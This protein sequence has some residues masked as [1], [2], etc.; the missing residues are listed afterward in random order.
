MKTVATKLFCAFIFI[1][2]LCKP[3]YNIISMPINKNALIRYK[4]LDRLLSDP[5]HLYSIAEL[6]EAVNNKLV[7]DGFKEVSKRCIEKDLVAL[8]DSPFGAPIEDVVKNGKRRWFYN[9]RSFSIFSEKMSSEERHLLHEVLGTLGQFEGLNHFDWLEKFKVGL[10]L[11]E[12]RKIISFSSNPYARGTNWLGVLFD[13]IA[14]E[15]VINLKYHT[16][17]EPTISKQLALHPYLLKQYHNRWHLIGAAFDDEFVLNFPL[18]RIDGVELLTDKRYQKC[19]DDLSERFEDIIGVTYYK[20]HEAE[21]I[22]FW[23]TGIAEDHISALPLHGSQKCYKGDDEARL[24]SAYPQLQGGSFYSI[25][26]MR[27]GEML[28][29]LCAYGS[30]LIVLKPSEI[31]NEICERIKMM[32]E[33]YLSVR[34]KNS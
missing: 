17:A 11:E 28:R 15:T 30:E 14:N 9:P 7:T 25:C 24:R 13:A 18:D 22:L 23:A 3:S 5:H 10:G 8:Q 29:E 31:Q 34:T 33:K 27:N 20:D 6:T 32:Q 2:Y 21:S 1:L 26:C 12:R 19:T 16:F 4:H